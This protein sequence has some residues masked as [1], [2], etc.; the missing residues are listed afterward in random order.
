MRY[1]PSNERHLLAKVKVL[2]ARCLLLEKQITVMKRG[3][4]ACKA[5]VRRLRF[6]E[7]W[8]SQPIAEMQ[9][10]I[11]TIFKDI[12]DFDYIDEMMNNVSTD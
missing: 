11:H 3:V 7:G 1:I 9:T 6:F 8:L 12:S 2:E 4:A 5:K 10:K